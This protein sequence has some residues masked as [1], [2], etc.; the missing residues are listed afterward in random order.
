[1]EVKIVNIYKNMRQYKGVL[2]G[3]NIKNGQALSLANK[4]SFFFILP[5]FPHLPVIIMG[6]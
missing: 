3:R 6:K 4:N 1:M 2:E 5:L